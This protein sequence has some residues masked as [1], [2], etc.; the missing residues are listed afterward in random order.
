VATEGLR[1]GSPLS[2]DQLA[3][4]YPANSAP[5]Q[6]DPAASRTVLPSP[7]RPSDG[8]W[9][10]ATTASPLAHVLAARELRV[11]LDNPRNRRG[12]EGRP[13]DADEPA[14]LV[15]AGSQ[16]RREARSEGPQPLLTSESPP[17]VPLPPPAPRTPSP[18]TTCAIDFEQGEPVIRTDRLDHEPVSG[19]DGA[20]STL[21]LAGQEITRTLPA[22][23]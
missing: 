9:L 1:L 7:D 19:G 18:A 11:S 13:S 6:H 17:R 16:L 21:L 15:M 5:E 2:A 3:V 22:T 12:S 10:V 14:W 4:E 8:A 20:R 23:L